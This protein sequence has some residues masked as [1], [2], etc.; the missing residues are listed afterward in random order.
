MLRRKLDIAGRAAGFCGVKNAKINEIIET[1]MGVGSMTMSCT[2]VQELTFEDGAE[3]HG[4]FR[5]DEC[6]F[7][8]K[9]RNNK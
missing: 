5:M 3:Y 7:K 8:N 9:I 4:M 6:D 2:L 1:L